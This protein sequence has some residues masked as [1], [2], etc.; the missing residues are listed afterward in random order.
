MFDRPEI[1]CAV[2]DRALAETKYLAM[3]A[4]Q[5]ACL[6]GRALRTRADWRYSTSPLRTRRSSK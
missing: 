3:A 6:V 2:A 5:S 4:C 1:P